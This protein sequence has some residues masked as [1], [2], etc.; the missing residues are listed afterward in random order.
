MKRR[1]RR[2]AKMVPKDM[3]KIPVDRFEVSFTF[4]PSLRLT[5][6]A[7]FYCIK[8]SSLIHCQKYM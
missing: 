2:A 8:I 6:P 1:G 5:D 4:D 3:L 7:K